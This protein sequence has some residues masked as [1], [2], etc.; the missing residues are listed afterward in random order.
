VIVPFIRF[1]IVNFISDV[2]SIL[3]LSPEIMLKLI[4]GHGGGIINRNLTL[5][6]VSL[7][8]LVI[9][10]NVSDVSAANTTSVDTNSIVKSS[11]TVK[12]YV[13]TKKTVPSTVTVA[14]KKVTKEQYLYL[15]ASS[16]TNLNKKTNKAVT[17]KTISKAPNPNENVKTGTLSK[18]E[19]IKIAGKI[20]SFVNT[21]NRLPNWVETSK[22]KMKPDNLIY[23]Y[24][25]ILAF[26]KTNKRLPNTV[27]VK[28][29]ST[30]SK[31]GSEG[32]GTRPVYILSDNI[33][34]KSVDNDR[35]N[36][37]VNELKKMGIKAYNMGAGTNNI[38]V[39]KKIPS[40]ALVV[41]IMGGACA[42]TIKETGSSWYKNLLGSR[43][44]FFVWT[45]GA[46][47]ITGLKWLERAHDDNF[48]A[49]SFKGLANPDKYLLQ[50]GYQY[51]EGYTN[52]KVTTLAK[53]IF[54]QA[55]G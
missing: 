26:Y 37:I 31:T 25:K 11:D 5:A 20:T 48:S 1:K 3:I 14:N 51:Y 22:G 45:E 38:A 39:F 23:T 27:S 47:K 19:Y 53:L 6:V 4:S 33:N 55:K 49:A 21:N 16:V 41:Q 46:K 13:E 8:A 9:F 32:T 17:V 29:W 24:S 42:A 50:N 30:I 15:L 54:N 28:P 52:S 36:R 12:N 7:L 44:L 35:I 43:K 10:I 34:N 2:L 40:N 18:S